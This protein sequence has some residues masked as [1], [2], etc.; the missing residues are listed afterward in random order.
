MVFESNVILELGNDDPATLI[1]SGH[2]TL[3][4]VEHRLSL[5]GRHPCHYIFAPISGGWYSRTALQKQ[6][7]ADYAAILINGPVDE[8]GD[9][10]INLIR[11]L[12]HVDTKK[13]MIVQGNTHDLVHAL[14][15]AVSRPARWHDHYVLV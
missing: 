9:R 10:R 7:P 14:E 4:C 12:N 11:H 3:Y 8:H 1:L 5:I 2:H 6:M 13:P 15:H